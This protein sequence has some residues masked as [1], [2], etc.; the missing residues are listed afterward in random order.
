[1]DEQMLRN[2]WLPDF[3]K[4]GQQYA[5]WVEMLQYLLLLVLAI[6]VFTLVVAFIDLLLLLRQESKK[7]QPLTLA[8]LKAMVRWFDTRV[9]NLAVWRAFAAMIH[10]A[11]AALHHARHVRFPH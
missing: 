2:P 10:T 1:M 7:T 5:M 11:S 9:T 3:I 4:D 8:L 6:A